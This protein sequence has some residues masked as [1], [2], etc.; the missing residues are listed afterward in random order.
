VLNFYTESVAVRLKDACIMLTQ[1]I[2]P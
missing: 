1:S 2:K